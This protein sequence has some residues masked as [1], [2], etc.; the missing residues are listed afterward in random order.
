MCKEAGSHLI[1]HG[2][3]E[4]DI[5]GCCVSRCRKQLIKGIARHLFDDNAQKLTRAISDGSPSAHEPREVVFTW[6]SPPLSI[7][8]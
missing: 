7:L 8:K 1:E 6:T 5:Q 2:L 4:A 3:N